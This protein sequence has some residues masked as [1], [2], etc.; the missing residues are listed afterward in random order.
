MDFQT[1]RNLF[2]L[3]L[4]EWLHSN[5]KVFKDLRCSHTMIILCGVCAQCRP[6]LSPAS[7]EQ[8]GHCDGQA[9]SSHNANYDFR[10]SD[11]WLISWWEP[12]S[13][14]GRGGHKHAAQLQGAA[15]LDR[16]EME[17]LIQVHSELGWHLFVWALSFESHS[18][19]LL[20]L[21]WKDHPFT[22][23]IVFKSFK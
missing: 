16:G 21:L 12:K 15:A 20:P 18:V 2:V 19:L 14:T 13:Q 10:G 6:C 4:M 17:T 1:H 11:R 8:S 22:K 5:W 23:C 3:Y 7:A 9:C